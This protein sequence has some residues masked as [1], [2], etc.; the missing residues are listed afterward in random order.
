MV[1]SD[2]GLTGANR[3]ELTP[4]TK[5]IIVLPLIVSILY[6]ASLGFILLIVNIISND[7]TIVADRGAISVDGGKTLVDGGVPPQGG[8]RI[9]FGLAEES[10]SD[11]RD[12]PHQNITI[13]GRTHAAK[14]VIVYAER[15]EVDSDS[16]LHHSSDIVVTVRR[17]VIAKK[18]SPDYSEVSPERPSY[19]IV[20]FLGDKLSYKNEDISADGIIVAGGR[21]AVSSGGGS[22]GM[23]ALLCSVYWVTAVLFLTFLY[24]SLWLCVQRQKGFKLLPGDGFAPERAGML[25]LG[26]SYLIFIISGVFPG[27]YAG[28]G[29]MVTKW[30]ATLFFLVPLYE[31]FVSS[32][33]K[34][35]VQKYIN[36]VRSEKNNGKGIDVVVENRSWPSSFW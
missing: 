18:K 28:S 2:D 5:S 8:S 15:V 7:V 12:E 20:R 30:V 21:V 19:G 4:I 23:V 13:D 33:K 3:W 14:G 34:L 32:W 27:L 9:V 24:R 25:G 11:G 35:R 16:S 29:N 17:G 22:A 10:K 6:L 31:V 26:L 1:A 36:V